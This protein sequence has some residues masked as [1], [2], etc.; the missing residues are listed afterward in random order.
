MKETKLTIETGIQRSSGKRKCLFNRCGWLLEPIHCTTFGQICN[1]YN[2]FFS[3]HVTQLKPQVS[4]C[5]ELSKA[6]T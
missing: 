1:K 2:R 3:R 4:M 6:V 5:L